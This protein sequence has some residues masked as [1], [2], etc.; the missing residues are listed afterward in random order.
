MTEK[1]DELHR[2]MCRQ[3]KL[4]E[5][6]TC[7]EENHQILIEHLSKADRKI[8][9]RMLDAQQTIGILQTQ[10]AF[11]QGFKLGLEISNE[12]QNYNDHSLEIENQ[13]YGHSFMP[14][15]E[16]EDEA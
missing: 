15:E 1:L 11:T 13:D 4:T 2:A 12:L 6:E 14:N 3:L 9:L 5:L 16:Q 10:N 7:V 8:V